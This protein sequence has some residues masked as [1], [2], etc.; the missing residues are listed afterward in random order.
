MSAVEPS[1]RSL[2][3]GG[4]LA[5][6]GGVAGFLVTRRTD[7]AKGAAGTVDAYGAAAPVH[8]Y[9][10]PAAANGYGATVTP[11]GHPLARLDQL[12]AGGGLVLGKSQVVLTRDAAGTVHC[13]TS[14]CTHQ[15]CSVNAVKNGTISCPCHGSRF[16]ARTGA[17]V[18]GPATAPLR[19][20]P[21]VVRDGTVFTG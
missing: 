9:G 14:L 13:F 3:R 10:A 12:P 8:A 2:M 5:V 17:A 7:A 4:A 16:D 11:T 1:R 15:G 6:V 21:V 20:V 18:H 19:A